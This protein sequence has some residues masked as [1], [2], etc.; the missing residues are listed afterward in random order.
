MTIVAVAA[1]VRSWEKKDG[2]KGEIVF[3]ADIIIVFI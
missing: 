3:F 1:G 2:W